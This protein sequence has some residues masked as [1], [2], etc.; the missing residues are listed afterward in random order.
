MTPGKDVAQIK[1]VMGTLLLIAILL[2]LW[3]TPITI[4]PADFG[5]IQ[6]SLDKPAQQAPKISMPICSD[7]D[8]QNF[9]FS[10]LKGR[11]FVV[12]IQS[13]C[14]GGV[15]RIPRA[16]H[17]S[18]IQPSGDQT[19]FWYS[20]WVVGEAR[21]RGP[22]GL[23]PR[24][25]IIYNQARFEGHGT[26][27]FYTNDVTEQS[28][29]EAAAPKPF[30]PN[31]PKLT[32]V[33][34]RGDD[35]HY[36]DRFN[37]AHKDVGGV[38]GIIPPKFLFSDSGDSNKVTWANGFKG[39]VPACYVIDEHGKTDNI[40]F[41]QPIPKDLEEHLRTELNGWHFNP[42]MDVQ[43]DANHQRKNQ[44]TRVQRMVNFIFR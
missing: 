20:I 40:Y 27:L 25:D 32:E 43:L 36:C 9:D 6:K 12:P 16:W 34:V 5:K 35:P 17:N 18:Y 7:A 14:F 22:F 1:L 4:L 33:D 37:D 30:Q 11:R 23:N 39:T 38:T 42:G 28:P 41:L 10:N 15:V 8:S 26:L 44:P 2:I 13:T 3:R 21:P 19:G 31:L 24:A 29:A